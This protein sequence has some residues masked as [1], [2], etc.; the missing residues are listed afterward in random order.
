M[1]QLLGLVQALF[2]RS[3]VV[4]K[5]ATVFMA[6]K[7][8]RCYTMEFL[9]KSQLPEQEID[10]FSGTGTGQTVKITLKSLTHKPIVDRFL[11]S[12]INAGGNDCF[13]TVSIVDF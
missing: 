8:D 5:G 13:T 6:Q 3:T 2:G 12:K 9:G 1:D 10:I 11:K 4:L 7:I